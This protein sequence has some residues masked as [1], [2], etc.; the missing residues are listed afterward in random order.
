MSDLRLP[1]SLNAKKESIPTDSRQ[2]T[3]IGA[4]GAGK[5][6]FMEEMTELNGHRAFTLN[7]LNAFF[8][9]TEES[10]RPGSID[11]LY[12]EAVRQQP[13]LRTDAMSRLDKVFYMLFADELETL[14]AFKERNGKGQRNK[15][16]PKSRLDKVREV[17]ERIFP[18]NKIVRSGGRV[19][20]ATGSGTDLIDA[21]RLSQGE[22]TVLYY[23][24]AVTFAMPHAVVF[25]DS[26]SLFLHHSIIGP[27]W[28]M[29]ER[30]R[31]DCTFI[32]NSVDVDFVS[33][34]KNNTCLWIKSYDS[35]QKA[36]DYSILETTPL[37][38]D[39]MVELAGS[40]RPVLFIEGDERHSI[41]MRLYSAV[42]HDRTV[43]PLGSCDKVIETTRTFNDLS[44]MHHLQSMGIV[45][46]DRRTDAEV[47]YLRAK[48][49]M[50][51]EVA[52]IENIF[53][54][55]AIIK[56][57]AAKRGRDSVKTLAIIKRDIIKLF[58][59]HIDSQALQH[60]RH[61]IKRDVECRIDGKF[62]CITAMEIHIRSLIHQLKPREH[63]NRLRSEFISMAD[64][65]DYDAILRVF[66]HKPM[67]AECN[68]HGRLGFR[69]PAEYINKVLEI[70]RNDDHDA[71]HL[72]KAVAHCLQFDMPQNIESKKE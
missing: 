15:P 35:G 7:A 26:P 45:D 27:L 38:E 69:S 65:G 3:I 71:D 17:W 4:N 31:P 42:F 67:M 36:W 60:T 16:M 52:E 33:S 47:Q 49:I 5:S 24:G 51:P 28:D 58:R 20:F 50:V 59:H 54:L 34:R 10:T 22:K 9:E 43:K 61:K 63:Y 29:I 40:R 56:T 55:P 48:H 66:N 72:R 12:R 64:K 32:Y 2:I 44:S 41:D 21:S 18:G 11:V 46:R 57:M 39:L 68:V 37:S 14:L 19:L 8:T 1:S 62:S 13:Y 6:R 23:L 70:M 30:M 25:I 53:L